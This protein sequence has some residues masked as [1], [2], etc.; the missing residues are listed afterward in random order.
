MFPFFS[1]VVVVSVFALSL[2][3]AVVPAAQAR[4]QVNRQVSTA[5]QGCVDKAMEWLNQVLG[6]E[7]K[8]AKKNLKKVTGK[9][10]C[11]IDPLGS[12]RC[13]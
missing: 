12:P 6:K 10:G 11:T 3:I 7:Q 4:M 2:N 5:D 8:G 13:P 1:R 9:D